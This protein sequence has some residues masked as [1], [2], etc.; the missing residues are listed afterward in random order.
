MQGH[1]FLGAGGGRLASLSAFGAAAFSS[2]VRN[3]AAAASVASVASVAY[4]RSWKEPPP[5][6]PDDR[7]AWCWACL[8]C[9]LRAVHPAPSLHTRAERASCARRCPARSKLVLNRALM[10][11]VCGGVGEIAQ[12]C[13]LYPLETLKVGRCWCTVRAHVCESLGRR[14]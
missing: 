11:A 12:I 4:V 7:C 13:L 8:L 5:K 3:A 2:N 14:G 6:A 10:E 9:A 1:S